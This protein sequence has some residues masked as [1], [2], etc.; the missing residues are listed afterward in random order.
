LLALARYR[1]Q[2][3]T[4]VLGRTIPEETIQRAVGLYVVAFGLI[5]LAI[6]VLTVTEVGAVPH[7][8]AEHG[9]L[10]YMFEAVSAFN[11]VGLSM[12][13]TS[14]LSPAGRIITTSLMYLGRVGPLTFAAAIALRSARGYGHLRYAYEDVVIG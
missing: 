11:T 7:P 6:L 10:R 8:T 2:P 5:T 3:T 4:N 12:G 14:E 9:L 13:V 1:G